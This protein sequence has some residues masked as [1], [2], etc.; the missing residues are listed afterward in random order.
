M[1]RFRPG[2]RPERLER[3][4]VRWRR[5]PN[6]SGGSASVHPDDTAR[7]VEDGIFFADGRFARVAYVE[8]EAFVDVVHFY[9]HA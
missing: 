7:Y 9:F 5:F 3:G 6:H 2:T 8:R 1:G 4:Q